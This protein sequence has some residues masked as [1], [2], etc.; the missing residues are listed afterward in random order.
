MFTKGAP[1]P[2]QTDLT[3]AAVTR[4]ANVG[5]PV[6][7]HDRA[8]AFYVHHL[9]FEVRRDAALGGGMR[10]VEVAPPGAA[11]TIALAPT[12]SGKS[13]GV[14]TGVRLSVAD[15]GAAHA[16]LSAAGVDV[17]REVMRWPGVPPMF[18]FRD[19]DGNTLY[20]V[21]DTEV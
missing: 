12:P 17:G 11:T 5:I 15:A 3:G 18:S 2:N 9:S 1:M 4:V 20:V 19:P 13:T 6:N 8:I 10:W 7:D 16:A 21:E 14:D